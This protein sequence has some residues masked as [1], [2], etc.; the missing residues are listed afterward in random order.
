MSLAGSLDDVSVAD[1]M[2]FINLGARSGTL[3]LIARAAE[4]LPDMPQMTAL[5]AW[6]G[7]RPTTPDHRPLIGPWPRS[8]ESEAD[9]HGDSA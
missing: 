3:A 2:Q 7:F 9:Q 1:V 6:T 4:Y 8:T 5:R